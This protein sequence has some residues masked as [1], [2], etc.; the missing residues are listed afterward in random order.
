MKIY[1]RT[2][3]IEG[4]KNHDFLTVNFGEETSI[5]GANGKGK[6]GISEAVTWLTYGIDMYGNKFDPTPLNS[7]KTPK[8]E[9]LLNADGKDLLLTKE[10]LK[11][12]KYF[13]N[14][15]P[16][17]ATEFDEVV[18]SLFEKELFMSIFSPSYFFSQH[19]QEQRKQLL[20]YIPEPVNKEVITNLN[21]LKSDLLTEKL[22]KYTI[23]DMVK[24]YQPRIK[25]KETEHERAAERY[26]TL[27]EQLDNSSEGEI[28][29]LAIKEEMQDIKEMVLKMNESNLEVNQ[30][31]SEYKTLQSNLNRLESEIKDVAK[32]V[33]KMNAT[34]LKD[35]CNTCGQTLQGEALEKATENRNG[36]IEAKKKIGSTLVKQF[37]ELQEK[38][39]FESVGTAKIVDTSELQERYYSLQNQLGS[40][41][42]VNKLKEQ[43][44]EAA[45]NKESVRQE[46]LEAQSV[47]EAIK[48]F[49]TKKSEMMVDKVNSL[50]DN[51]TVKLFDVKKN[52]SITPTFEVEMDQKPY[53]KLST[54]EKIKAG[55][56]LAQVLI[57][58]SE[59][60]VPVFVDNAESILK[61][62]A[63][64]AQIIT[65][66]VKTGD[67]K[68]E[69]KGELK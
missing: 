22:K 51:L 31:L 50:L 8:V 4:F 9:L 40:V 54:A 57:Q 6:S 30:K 33:N 7:D 39:K 26:L 41:D 12:A 65:A 48:D 20:Q 25:S 61:F 59:T 2:L 18:S 43:V 13:V 10:L 14:E 45:Q 3:T 23:D 63:P 38:I 17:K 49:N 35:S 66:K 68:I 67:L 19:W 69:A 24:V 56:E 27:K 29:E 46:L 64:T 1:F 28:D 55:L 44:E 21:Q 34:P 5:V 37:K 36:E 32:I 58:Q 42:R 47:I 16:K 15:V 52:G 60:S 53:S 62:K 11:S